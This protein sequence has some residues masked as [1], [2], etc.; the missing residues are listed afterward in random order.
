ML[1]MTGAFREAF[2]GA[3]VRALAMSGVA[4][5]AESP[6]LEEA[7]RALERELRAAGDLGG[8]PVLHAYV[9]HYR[10]FGKSSM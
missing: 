10:A 6:A 5:P 4:N 3:V 1:T 9:D 2:P 8:N 7:K